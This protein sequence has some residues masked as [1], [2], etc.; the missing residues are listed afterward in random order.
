MNEKEALVKIQEVVDESSKKYMRSALMK[1]VYT[2]HLTDKDVYYC[3]GDDQPNLV[4][5][6]FVSEN[7]DKF[8]EIENLEETIE[9]TRHFRVDLLPKLDS[10]STA[11]TENDTYDIEIENPLDNGGV[12]VKLKSS[13]G[14]EIT[15]V[16][17]YRYFD[18]VSKIFFVSCISLSYG[19]QY[20]FS[21]LPGG[22]QMRIILTNEEAVRSRVN[23]ITELLT[24]RAL[25]SYRTIE[26]GNKLLQGEIKAQITLDGED[27]KPVK[28]QCNFC[29]DDPKTETRFAFFGKLNDKGE[30]DENHGGIILVC[31]IFNNNTLKTADHWSEEQKKSLE[32]IREKLR[33]NDSDTQDHVASYFADDLDFRYKA[34]KE[35]RLPTE[36]K[37][38]EAK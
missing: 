37:P 26:E 35:G 14:R 18:F 38:T 19:G 29:Y 5:R 13:V 6:I 9:Y 24:N 27:G 30:E 21:V 17:I 20:L 33:N 28:Y 32:E 11:V 31:D 36:E 7:D 12:E 25:P 22:K 1:I 16:E 34:F 10:V 23:M 4:L 2:E 3:I 15:M 8:K